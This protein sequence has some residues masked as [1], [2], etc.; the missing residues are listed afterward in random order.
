[1]VL[2]KTECH[3]SNCLRP[4]TIN[5]NQPTRI[6]TKR[7]TPRPSAMPTSSPSVN[8]CLLLKISGFSKPIFLKRNRLEG[9]LW[10]NNHGNKLSVTRFGK[11]DYSFVLLVESN[12]YQG[13]ADRL[14]PEAVISWKSGIRIY[15]DCYGM[16]LNSSFVGTNPF[17]HFFSNIFA[18]NVNPSNIKISI[19]T[20][21][22]NA[23]QFPNL[24]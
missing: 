8:P 15:A 9:K 7:S 24:R 22:T 16:A 1:M 20:S 4:S 14:D 2:F 11:N 18:N 13:K 12:F 6:P 17:G 10:Q 23:N 5:I 3:L 21:N 19:I